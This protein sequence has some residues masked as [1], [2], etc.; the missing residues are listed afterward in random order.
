V[1]VL[2]A[3]LASAVPVLVGVLAAPRRTTALVD[4]L[5]AV[6][7][8]AALALLT[9]GLHLDGLA[10]TVDGLGVKGVDGVD[11]AVVER[12]LAVMRAPDVGAFGAVALVLV[13][14]LQVTALAVSTS[15]GIGT[16]ALVVAA[17]TGRLAATWC[18]AVG[19]PSARPDGLGAAVA[20][21]VPRTAALAM[22]IVVLVGAALLGSVQLHPPLTTALGGQVDPRASVALVVAVL[23][24]LGAGALLLR[25]CVV[26]FGGIT[27]DVLGAVVEVTTTAALVAIALASSYL[28]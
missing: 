11:S 20:G 25:R 10:D 5:T 9:R 7:A 3:L 23:V 14:L 24:G 28:T 13:V 21:T 2:L 27:G 18:C 8:V 19:V 12:R 17:A 22:T 1:G 16:A 6:L 4:L 15:A 26:R